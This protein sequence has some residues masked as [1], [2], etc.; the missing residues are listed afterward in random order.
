MEFLETKRNE[1]NRGM[2]VSN[3]SPMNYVTRESAPRVDNIWNSIVEI[4]ETFE[5]MR[6]L[7]WIVSVYVNVYVQLDIQYV[8]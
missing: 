6:Y 8:L 5:K 4:L 2:H 1:E 7:S 3:V